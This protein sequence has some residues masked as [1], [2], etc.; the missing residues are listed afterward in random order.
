MAQD[1]WFRV[2]CQEHVKTTTRIFFPTS[3]LSHFLNN[4]LG[5]GGGNIII[6]NNNNKRKKW[7]TYWKKSEKHFWCQCFDFLSCTVCLTII[8]IYFIL[9][10]FFLNDV[11]SPPQ[12][13]P[14]SRA[15]LSEQPHH[16]VPHLSHL[17]SPLV[18]V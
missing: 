18:S 2:S 8:F 9:Y 5:R 11:L 12:I 3:V 17:I 15:F 7:I 13:K 6:I 10:Y 4:D 16:L 1:Q 14:F